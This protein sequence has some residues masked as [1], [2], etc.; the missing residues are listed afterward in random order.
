LI[1]ARL[2]A[3]ASVLPGRAISTAELVERAMP[4][5]PA[6]EVVRKTGISARHFAGPGDSVAS[7]G[8]AALRQALEG[9][10]LDAGALRRIVL[11]TSTGGDRAIPATAHAVAEAVGA[12]GACDA[13]D[14]NNACMGFLTAFDLA[15]RS[16]ATGREPVAVVVVETLS[17]NVAPSSPRPYL[18]LG[19]AAVAVIVGRGEGGAGLL[20]SS[21]ASRGEVRSGVTMAH[22]ASPLVEF[23]A[24]SEEMTE[25]AIRCLGESV[26]AALAEARLGLDEIEWVLPHQPN[27]TM[28]ERIAQRLGLRAERVVPVVAEVGSV[29]AAS[30]ALSL[31]RLV[32]GRG[33]RAGERVLLAG[34]GAGTAHGALIYK[35]GLMQ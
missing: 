23:A 4:G 11:V 17:R 24:S 22:G 32:R 29:G 18:V 28:L 8:A 13:F 7:L 14:L 33:L 26:A 34:V 16:A 30:V 1:P 25:A 19:D 2:I 5:R 20:A 35:H 31:D 3:T 10:R 6:N 9:A 15:A 27:G 21:L 12:S